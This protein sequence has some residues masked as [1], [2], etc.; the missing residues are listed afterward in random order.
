MPSADAGWAPDL[1][2]GGTKSERVYMVE[3][4][5]NLVDRSWGPTNAASRF[6]RVKV[7]MPEE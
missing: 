6:F 1:D 5:T 4:K 7:E 3:G 2:E